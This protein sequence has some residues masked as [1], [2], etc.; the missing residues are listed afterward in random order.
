MCVRMCVRAYVCKTFWLVG[1][2]K[3]HD[4]KQNIKLTLT[5]NDGIKKLTANE[6]RSFR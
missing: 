3:L 6:V 2:P 1:I 5:K 4:L